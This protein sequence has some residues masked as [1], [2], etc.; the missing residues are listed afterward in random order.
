[1]NKEISTTSY[2]KQPCPYISEP[3]SDKMTAP[4]TATHRVPNYLHTYGP[5]RP[6]TSV[7]K[8]NRGRKFN[9]FNSHCLQSKQQMSK[10]INV[11]VNV[12][13]NDLREDKCACY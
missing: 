7:L 5:P 9:Y 11:D 1:M 13:V 12:V 6:P 10:T 8:A 4:L 2:K 3:N